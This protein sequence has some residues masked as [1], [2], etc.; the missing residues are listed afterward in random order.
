MSGREPTTILKSVIEGQ[1]RGAKLR[2]KLVANKEQNWL[3]ALTLNSFAKQVAN[4]PLTDLEQI[5]VDTFHKEGL[6]L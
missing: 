3:L 5:I 2:S 1:G 4:T 6:R